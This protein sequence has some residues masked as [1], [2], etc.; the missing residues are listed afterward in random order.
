MLSRTAPQAGCFEGRSAGACRA[1][2][3]DRQEDCGRRYSY[4]DL[5]AGTFTSEG[6][7]STSAKRGQFLGGMFTNDNL[8]A[9]ILNTLRL[10]QAPISSH[11]CAIR[12]ALQKDI[13]CGSRA[14]GPVPCTIGILTR[15]HSGQ[16]PPSQAAFA[17]HHDDEDGD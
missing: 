10:A 11:E 12:V 8:S 13:P 17:D 2:R 3:G 14:T 6:C 1:D 16:L 4:S 5:R 15:R 9:R 7:L